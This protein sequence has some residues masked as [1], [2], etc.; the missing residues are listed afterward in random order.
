M[1]APIGQ[2]ENWLTEKLLSLNPDTDTEVFS[3]YISGIL[4]EDGEEDEK[5]EAVIGLIDQ[6]VVWPFCQ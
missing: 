3:S 5:R 2:F 1:A 6:V 4:E